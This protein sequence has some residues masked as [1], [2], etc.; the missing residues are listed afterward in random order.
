MSFPRYLFAALVVALAVPVFAPLAA[1]SATP[2]PMPLGTLPPLQTIEHLVVHPLC[3]AL[4]QNI[5]PAIGMVLKNDAAIAKAP[6]LLDDFN[7]A[8]GNGDANKGRMNI[9]LLRMENLVGPL[10]ANILA[11]QKK[12][13]D[14][15]VFPKHARNEEERT[16]LKIRDDLRK[17]LAAQ[18][19]QL[20]V[21]NG[22][23]QTQQLHQ[24]QHEGFGYIN[25]INGQDMKSRP[26]ATPTPGPFSADQRFSAGLD[27]PEHVIDP[28]TIPGLTL[29][30]NP[31]TRLVGAMHYVQKEGQSNE[32]HAAASVMRGVQRCQ[33]LTAPRK[34]T[35]VII[36]P[37]P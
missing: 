22:F 24:M 15:E 36:T 32:Q 26:M 30:Y 2:T 8:L 20:D 9:A 19:F 1:T 14:P 37:H 34:P 7:K 25:A 21:I 27:Q 23:V 5:G 28:S 18:S 13:D 10:T 33:A 11:I 16:M 31:I 12:L 4:K 6:P 35:E 3:F 29:G 17:T